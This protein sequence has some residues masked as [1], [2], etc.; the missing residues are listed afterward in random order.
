MG[1]N[2]LMFGVHEYWISKLIGRV[3]KE[4]KKRVSIKKTIEDAP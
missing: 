3:I 1:L 4:P 2:N